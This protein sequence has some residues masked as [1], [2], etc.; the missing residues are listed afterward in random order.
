M[1][2]S[3]PVRWTAAIAGVALHTAISAGY[4]R[5]QAMPDAPFDSAYFAW[6]AG[7]YPRALATLDRLLSGGAAARY[8][9]PAALLT[10]ELYETTEVA[11]D[12]RA[13]R[14][15]GDGM[16]AAYEAGTGAAT[17][18]YI[19]RVGSGPVRE[20]AVIKGRA[21]LVSNGAA[22]IDGND[23]VV[24]DLGSGTEQ[25]L[26][27]LQATLLIVSPDGVLHYTAGS[28]GNVQLYR[29]E[30]TRGV[31]LTAGDGA[32][33]SVSWLADGTLVYSVNAES[34]GLLRAGAMPSSAT[35]IEGS[36]VTVSADRSTFAYL[37]RNGTAYRI[38]VAR[39]DGAPVFE[40]STPYALA[41][42]RLSADGRRVVYQAMPREDWELYVAEQGAAAASTPGRLTHDIQH[43]LMPQF[44]DD[45]RILSA[46]GEGRHRRSYIYD[47][48]TGARSRLFHN[49]TIRTVAPEYE[50]AVS[51]DG[52]RI[53]I[54]AERDGDTVSPE[55]GV[56]LVDLTR[57]VAASTVLSRVRTMRAAELDL[58]TRGR[59]MYAPI[60]AAVNAA[61]AD[62]SKDRI[63][64]YAS[65]LFAFDS[66]YISQ[67]GNAKAI[68]YLAAKL[69]SW[70]YEPELQY[71]EAAGR[72]GAPAVRTANVIARLRGTMDQDA[73]YVVSSH[74]DS[75]LAGAGADDNTS[76]TSALLEAA[77]VLAKRPQ[78]RTIEF[79]FFTGEE[80]GLLGS[81]EYVRRA[82]A[83]K[84][85]II[86]ALNNDMVGFANDQ[87]MDNTIRYSNVGIRDVQHGA[88]L[89]F[90]KLIT[91]D[92]KYYKNTD[93]HAYY[94]AYGDI[95]G[96][97]GS[98]PILA[99]PH[100]HQSHDVLET[101]N[102]QLVAE[103]SKATVATLM[104]LTA[105]PSRPSGVAAERAGNGMRVSWN[106]AP[107][108]DV[109]SYRIEWGAPGAPAR[110]S[111][112]VQ[113]GAATSAS[114]V[115]VRAGDEIRVAAVNA[116]GMVAWD[117][118]RVVAK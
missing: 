57:E 83:D 20:V 82:L 14:W 88:A 73:T 62:I 39:A 78:A 75:V 71:F 16:Y 92:A 115:G 40:V 42:P 74:F 107:E 21:V 49:N 3:Q 103:V 9:T 36:A 19:V 45:A 72:N 77:R 10:G 69:R 23:I 29:M 22:Y 8:R 51:P 105:S 37:A 28:A 87:R 117:W 91:Y 61:V 31:A 96:G 25:R 18:T 43:N 80:A 111:L 64:A 76:G 58:R 95:V 12:G 99:N 116:R 1:N 90:T 47:A 17:M 100:Y 85:N 32:K 84:K 13:V 11:R 5:A 98:Y 34:F 30:G 101:I 53:L 109:R 66:K 108:S 86:G 38:V 54:V 33:T 68:E 59:A 110:G 89:G 41:A 50:W 26:T 60:M 104:L 118:A 2:Y 93:A 79:A 24:R 6:E 81:R 65:D 114:L 102:Q 35:I 44:I 4:V 67:P 48:A 112:R 113:G 70:G 27:G 97:I 63:Y 46:A 106:A 7:D 94:D 55:R 56:Y 15:S 52:K